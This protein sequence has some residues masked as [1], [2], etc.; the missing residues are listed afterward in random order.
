MSWSRK[1]INIINIVFERDELVL[2][3]IDFRNPCDL[4]DGPPSAAVLGKAAK[5]VYLVCPIRPSDAAF[6]HFFFETMTFL[7][8]RTATCALTNLRGVSQSGSHA[9]EARSIDIYFQRIAYE[10]HKQ[11]SS[12]L[13]INCTP[14][15][16]DAHVLQ[17]EVQYAP[18]D[19]TFALPLQVKPWHP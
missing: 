16:L 14:W 5:L 6:E 11:H 15:V 4:F 13:K 7:S 10:I 12:G 3:I 1:F 2:C 8:Y 9:R 18:T 19:L 17:L